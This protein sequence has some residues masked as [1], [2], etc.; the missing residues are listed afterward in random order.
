MSIFPI[1]MIAQRQLCVNSVCSIPH[2]ATNMCPS[3]V[4]R[5]VR[6]IVNLFVEKKIIDELKRGKEVESN[7]RLGILSC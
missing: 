5:E 1:D 7:E 4:D 2:D 6:G 3:C